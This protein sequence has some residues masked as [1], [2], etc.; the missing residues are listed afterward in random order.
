MLNVWSI[1]PIKQ[2]LDRHDMQFRSIIVSSELYF[3]VC[4]AAA[5]V[6]LFNY[7]WCILIIIFEL[8]FIMNNA[9]S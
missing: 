8:L 6:Y 4:D 3:R 7:I 9:S 5:T 2:I 1:H